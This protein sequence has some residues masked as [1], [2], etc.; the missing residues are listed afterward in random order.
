MSKMFRRD[1]SR[2]D[3]SHHFRTFDDFYSLTPCTG[4]TTIEY[5]S[6]ELDV[7]YDDR[8]ADTT[9]ICF[10]AAS[11][12]TAYPLFSSLRVT[13]DLEANVLCISDPILSRGTNLGW[14]AGASTQPLQIDLPK[15]LQHFLTLRNPNPL[16]IF[17]G[18]S[19]GGF[20]SMFYS[21]AFPDSISIA[22]NPQTDLSEY[23]ES[24][25][26]EYLRSA[27]KT[28]SLKETPIVSEL[29]SLYKDGFPNH[30]FIMQ[31]VADA[32][33]RD[34]HIAPWM[35]K[36]PPG[37]DRLNLLMDDWGVGHTPPPYQLIQ[38]VLQSVISNDQDALNNLGFIN[39][40]RQDEPAHIFRTWKE[41]RY[42]Q[43]PVLA[44]D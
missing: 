18:A 7:F 30:L 28:E 20:A 29:A 12:S 11:Q 34:R 26:K 16:P 8:Q 35:R 2:F 22:I 44:E 19:G 21:H 42:K 32:H 33:H 14:Y 24:S 36:V 6:T 23:K 38:K 17:F 40:P 9:V 43:V 13:A 15:V 1:I 25:V 37:S 41:S 4:L 10:H 27:W 39:S 3:E 31:N 5:G